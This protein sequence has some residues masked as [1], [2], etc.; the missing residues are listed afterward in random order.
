MMIFHSN[1]MKGSDCKVFC[2]LHDK[3]KQAAI[4]ISK[5]TM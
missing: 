1:S 4:F 5:I 3:M 2:T